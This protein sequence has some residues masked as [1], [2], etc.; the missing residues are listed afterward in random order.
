MN[1]RIYNFSSVNSKTGKPT[2]SKD[3]QAAYRHAKKLGMTMPKYRKHQEKEFKRLYAF[4]Y[5]KDYG[6]AAVAFKQAIQEVHPDH[7]GDPE[8]AKRIIVAWDKY[9]KSNGW[10]G[11]APKVTPEPVAAN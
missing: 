6:K 4:M 2:T 1:P 5:T 11:P 3:R 7:G 9:R 10:T 8:A